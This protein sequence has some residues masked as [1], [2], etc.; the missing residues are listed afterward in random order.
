MNSSEKSIND[1]GPKDR[2]AS[3]ARLSRGL[4]ERLG[5]DTVRPLSAHCTEPESPS[6][7]Q[8]IAP[9][10]SKPQPRPEPKP[11]R[12]EPE[13]KPPSPE[14]EL[15]PPLPEPQPRPPVQEE[16]TPAPVRDES[17]PPIVQE[18]APG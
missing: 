8:T 14:Q 16:V 3:K 11:P 1:V 15:R 5:S 9:P 17:R 10:G 18:I 13:P 7:D 2:H 4:H 12:P 6:L